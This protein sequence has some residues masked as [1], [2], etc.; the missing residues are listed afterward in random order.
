VRSSIIALLAARRRRFCHS[1]ALA[2]DELE[3][4][5]EIVDIFHSA[6]LSESHDPALCSATR[7]LLAAQNPDGSWG[8]P[9]PDDDYYDQVH[10]TWTAVHGLRTRIFLSGTPF[11]RRRKVLSGEIDDLAK[12]APASPDGR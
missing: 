12:G 11:D 3:L 9:E 7:R 5:A 6:G 2:Q 10:P 8:T 1:A 4:A